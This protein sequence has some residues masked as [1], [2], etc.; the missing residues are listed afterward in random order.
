MIFAKEMERE[1]EI[2]T[3]P[4]E[5]AE[6]AVTDCDI[7]CTAT[8]SSRPV[9][10]ADWLKAGM[11]Y[12]A[13]REFEMDEAALAK[14]MS[15]PSI[16]NL[17]AFN[18][19]NRPESSR[20]CPAYA[21]RRRETGAAILKF[22]ILS[23]AKLPAAPAI[24]KSPFSQQCWHGSTICRHGLLRLPRRKREWIRPRNSDRLVF[25]RYQ[26]VKVQSHLSKI[27][28]G[29]NLLRSALFSHQFLQSF[30]H[31]GRLGHHFLG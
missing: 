17:A 5:N 15:S 31:L 4:V 21:A 22:P 28:F 11:H 27:G 2:P 1:T 18:I 10:K 6:R 24:N 3:D 13:I 23:P 9:V 30:N 20:T 16:L 29:S 12:N 26:T 8:N 7:V 19:T 25:A 14:A